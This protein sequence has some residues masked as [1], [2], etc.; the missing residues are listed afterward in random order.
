[1]QRQRNPG[2]LHPG[3]TA[4]IQRIFH[5]PASVLSPAMRWFSAS[6]ERAASKSA[7][8]SHKVW[9]KSLLFFSI[10]PVSIGVSILSKESARTRLMECG[11]KN[12]ERIRLD[13]GADF[14]HQLLVIM[15]VVDGVEARAEDFKIG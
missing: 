12:F 15:Q 7:S 6:S 13:C 5:A 1:M 10:A 14:A 3:R 9:M 4:P 11:N 2:H 8:S